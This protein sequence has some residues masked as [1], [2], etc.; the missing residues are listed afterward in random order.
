MCLI[1]LFFKLDVVDFEV[2]CVYQCI[3]RLVVC[4]LVVWME[5]GRFYKVDERVFGFMIWFGGVVE[6][7]GG[8]VGC[9][10]RQVGQEVVVVDGE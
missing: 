3:R 5:E 6:E 10:D 2:G 9:V 1:I 8:E 4:R 7:V